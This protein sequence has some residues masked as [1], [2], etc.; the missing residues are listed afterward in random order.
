MVGLDFVQN[1]ALNV[2]ECIVEALMHFS[3][4][5]AQRV[6]NGDEINIRDPVL[7]EPGFS[8]SENDH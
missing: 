6:V 1:L 4:V 5:I 2:A 7:D 8:S 3:S